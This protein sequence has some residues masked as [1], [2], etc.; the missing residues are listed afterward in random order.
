MP[1]ILK[2]A[3]TFNSYIGEKGIV[4]NH[5]EAKVFKTKKLAIEHSKSLE[6]EATVMKVTENKN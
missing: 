4:K 1:W 3:N 2:K 6:F 5:S